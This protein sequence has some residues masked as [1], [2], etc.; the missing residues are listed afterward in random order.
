MIQP[1]L[2]EAVH[3]VHELLSLLEHNDRDEYYENKA[4]NLVNRY[5][6]VME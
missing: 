1:E 3:L 4:R 5:E 2:I 6:E